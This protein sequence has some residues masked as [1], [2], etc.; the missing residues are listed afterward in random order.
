[1]PFVENGSVRIHYERRGRGP[2]LVFHTGAGGDAR[3]WRDA[4]Y[5]TALPRFQLVT[6]DQR[7]RGLS[8]RPDRVEDHRMECFVSDVVC[9]LDELGVDSCGFWGYSNGAMVGVALG[10]EH[11][12]RLKA[13]VGTGSFPFIDLAELSPLPS[14]E[15]EM[16][17][18]V[19]AGGVLH[20]LEVHQT[21]T[22]ERFPGPI[23]ENVRETDPRMYALDSI[24]WRSWRGPR[25]TYPSFPA[26]VLA[27][28][29]ERED[30]S[31]QTE[32]SMAIV[33]KGRVV[34]LT[35]L[36]H[37]AAFYRSDLALPHARPFLERTL[38]VG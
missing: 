33:P 6:I 27:I 4:G 13:L 17:K 31:R 38:G 20:D 36:G 34:R 5:L 26:P 15:E 11:P 29:G 8:G 30:P 9:V 25:S 16:Q 1:M 7:G 2:T 21:R 32:A 22:G 37:L 10:A 23:D 3:M 24:A 35:G 14:V 18:L 28:T 19:A 12:R